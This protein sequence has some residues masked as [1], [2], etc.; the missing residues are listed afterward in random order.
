MKSHAKVVV[1]GGGVVGVSALYHL[2]RKGWGEDIVLLEK[3]ELTSGSTWH[4]AGLLPLFNM[5]YSVGQVHK[6]SVNLY[7]QLEEETGQSVGFRQVGN[8]RLAMNQ[9][10]MDEYYQYAATARTIGINVQFLT[11]DEIYRKWPLCNPEGL[12]GGIFHPDDGYIQPADLTQALAKGA[13]A[14]G[15]TIHRNTAVIG[16]EQQPAGNWLINTS[17]GDISCE[18][19]V[20]A[21]GN[22]AR[23][24]GAMVGLDIP[25][26]PVQHQYIVTEPHPELVRRKQNGEPELGVLRESDGSW[27]LR[28]ENDGF[29]LGPYEK[30]APACYVDG[31]DPSAEYELFQE[32]L[33]RLTP[34]IEAAI[35]RVPA[36]AE[37]GIK[38]VYNGAIAYTP[39]GNPIVGPA[40]DRDNFWLN[41]GHSFGITA[42]GGAGWQLAEWIVE[43]EPTIDMLGIEPRR[44]GDYANK[45]YLVAKNEEAYANV[46]VIHYPDEERPAARPLRTAPC[47][48]RL[49]KMG[50]VFGQKFGWERPNWFASE[51]M[52]AEDDWSFRRSKWF[53]AIGREV[54]NV[55]SNVGLLDMT[56]FA[57]CRVSGPGAESFLDYFVANR[58]PRKIGGIGL[59]HALNSHG[60]VHS[61]FTIVRESSGSFYLVSAG[62]LQR[63]D[64]DYLRKFMPRDGS[65]RFTQLTS[66]QGVLVLSG[67]RSKELLERVSSADFSNRAFRWLT[68]QNIR[69]N[70]APVTAMRVNY[71]GELGWEIH[72]SLEYQ[73][74]IFDAL[75]EAGE[76]LGLKP[77]G[78]RAMDSMRLEKSYRMVGTELSIEYSAYESALDRFIQPDKGDF[79]GRDALLASKHAGLNNLLVTLEVKNVEDADALGNNALT[80]DGELVGRATGGGFG[81]RV[82]KS[83]ALGMV[84]AE[85]AIPGTELQIEIL[86]KTFDC[87]I[88]PESP[89]DPENERLRN[90]NGAN[91]V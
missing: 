45:D 1:I 83:L 55:T 82:N 49:K 87:V 33:D 64:H 51:G 88:V 30:D 80:L 42:A 20:S 44:F 37:V 52:A 79:L 21:S 36:F 13:R 31:P 28:E 41:E 73:N 77:F 15:A 67:P 2:A 60:G 84:K 23:Q 54:A 89:F 6:Y 18:H 35:S 48:E 8:L 63:L 3:A 58:L 29:I 43:G 76:D 59:C 19:I 53:A 32:D 50:A 78:I 9:D 11:P 65:V 16:I 4:A 69:I 91:N 85:L 56:A 17:Q 61:E 27:Y 90:V 75:F 26:I 71:V 40:W 34:H 5:S 86:G 25:V 24:T 12:V 74:R 47:Y 62:A 57:K 38:Q 10:R 70:M 46:F 7:Q 14:R 39:D 81:F 22:Y 66:S 68:A 72:H